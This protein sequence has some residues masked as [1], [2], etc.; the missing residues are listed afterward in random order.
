[1]SILM[2]QNFVVSLLNLWAWASNK[3]KSN[4][5]FGVYSFSLNASKARSHGVEDNG[6]MTLYLLGKNFQISVFVY[7]DVNN[8][9]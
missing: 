7:I 4:L 6:I 9:L 5:G 2:K 1:M 8:G 3:T